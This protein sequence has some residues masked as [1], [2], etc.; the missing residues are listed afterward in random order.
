MPR[1]ADSQIGEDDGCHVGSNLRSGGLSGVSRGERQSREAQLV[2]ACG[3]RSML[4]MLFETGSRVELPLKHDLLV[5]LLFAHRLAAPAPAVP[6][7]AAQSSCRYKASNSPGVNLACRKM[8]RNV[9][10][11]MARFP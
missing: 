4:V 6:I 11:R 8:E 5:W 2:P 3:S 10:M 1:F 7:V 9:P